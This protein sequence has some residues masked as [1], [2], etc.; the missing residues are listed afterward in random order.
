MAIVQT[1]NGDAFIAGNLS[2][3]SM[4][5]PSGTVVD[6]DV[7]ATADFAAT[8]LEHQHQKVYAQESA[9]PAA[10]E[11]RVVHAVY[12]STGSIIAF[13]AG[14]VVACVGDSTITID[15]HKNSSSILTTP[16]VLDSSNSAYT[17]EAGTIDTATLVD[18]D[19]LEVVITV[20]AGTGT[21]GKGLFASVI[22]R[23]DPQ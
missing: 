4:N 2:A 3:R 1:I 21:L 9:T 23:E 6:A 18:G 8:K 11:D 19:V 7:A 10:A 5:I 20:S 14:S 13:E 17:P 16:I 22:I 12:G 15:L